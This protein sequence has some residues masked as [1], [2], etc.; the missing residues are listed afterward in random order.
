MGFNRA[1]VA[2]GDKT[3][4]ID[5]DFLLAYTNKWIVGR[6]VSFRRQL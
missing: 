1:R 5:Y 3:V 4:R 6:R 2:D